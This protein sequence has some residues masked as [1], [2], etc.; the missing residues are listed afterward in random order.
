M[1]EYVFMLVILFAGF[2]LIA[3]RINPILSIYWHF[4]NTNTPS[5]TRPKYDPNKLFWF[6]HVSDIHIRDTHLN[7]TRFKEFC[8][9]TLSNIA[10]AFLI[11]TGDLTH[12][13]YEPEN[14]PK[15][16]TD[17]LDRVINRHITYQSLA[18]W[19]AYLN[20]AKQADKLLRTNV[21]PMHQ[22]NHL[23]SND[24]FVFD[25]C[26]NHDRFSVDSHG[27][28]HYYEQYSMF[29]GKQLLHSRV[30]SFEYHTHWNET[31]QFIG[32]DFSP[33]PGVF[34]P[35][36]FFGTTNQKQTD[37]VD[38]LLE[39][40][41]NAIVFGHYPQS[42]VTSM[43]GATLAD[44]S[45]KHHYYAY[46]SGHLHT[47]HGL[48][49]HMVAKHGSGHMEI[50]IPDFF[51]H[52]AY[53]VIAIDNGMVSSVDALHGPGSPVMLITNPKDCRYSSDR[54]SSYAGSMMQS[55]EHIQVLFFARHP[56]RSVQIEIDGELIT[57]PESSLKPVIENVYR[58]PWDPK[59]FLNDSHLLSIR[60]EDTN[61]N[62]AKATKK[63]QLDGQSC[64]DLTF[65]RIKANLI[66]MTDFTFTF[67]FIAAAI[68]VVMVVTIPLGKFWIPTYHKYQLPFSGLLQGSRNMNAKRPYFTFIV[69]L[70]SAYFLFGP[71]FV[72]EVTH[73]RFGIVFESSIRVLEHSAGENLFQVLYKYYFT[74]GS[75]KAHDIPTADPLYRILP[76]FIFTYVPFVLFMWY[77]YSE[78]NTF[79]ERLLGKNKIIIV[80]G[81]LIILNSLWL[82]HTYYRHVVRTYGKYALLFG[83]YGIYL[84]VFIT[85]SVASIIQNTVRSRNKPKSE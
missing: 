49:K 26:G 55:S 69:F 83:V 54:E 25:I 75:T 36:N 30:G 3:H 2:Q 78:I 23:S 14:K 15:R 12:S 31:F 42:I 59:R 10:P 64:S 7:D 48:V 35:Y 46:L 18:E 70:F 19:Q 29:G 27:G 52:D 79:I 60:M 24:T 82:M 77:Y 11:I 74:D 41:D 65:N 81:V 22:R 40:N 33:L 9:T 50:E 73:D 57:V 66:L 34:P 62:V 56:L 80:T 61:G 13:S 1:K 17:V 53:R 21:H 32:V 84:P 71:W 16:E 39:K 68:C 47:M 67:R 72:G 37:Q 76:T 63:F 38:Q 20:V 43:K 44:L 51:G 6:V 45:K 28:H 8:N 4:T 85:L 5:I 58:F